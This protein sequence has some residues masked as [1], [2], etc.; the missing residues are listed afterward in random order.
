MDQNTTE[1][2]DS[3]LILSQEIPEG[4][5]DPNENNRPEDDAEKR[6]NRPEPRDKYAV[7]SNKFSEA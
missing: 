5:D 6:S 7:L 1:H 3:N 4:A 2:D